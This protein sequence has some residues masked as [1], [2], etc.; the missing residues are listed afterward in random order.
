MAQFLPD[1]LKDQND[2]PEAI[3]AS[4]A[5]LN[6]GNTRD[7]QTHL[8][9]AVTL[10]GTCQHMCPDEE[11][12]RRQRESDIQLLERLMPDGTFHPKDWTL[13][14]T[15]VK[16]F[17]RSA[18]DYKLDVPEW[19][20]PADVLENVCGYLEEWVMDR[21]R[22][23]PDP[24][25]NNNATPNPLDVYQF[26]WDRT[27][28]I[29]KDFTL[30]NYVGTGGNCDARAVRCHERIARWH[31]MCEHQLSHIPDFVT[32]QSQQNIQELGQ[33]LI[34]LNQFYD[35]TQRRCLVEVASATDGSESRPDSSSFD[36]G[37]KSDHV[38]GAPPVDYD[39]KPLAN[40]GDPA[41]ASRL[42]GK[43]AVNSPHHGTAEPEMRGLY[44]L[45]TMNNDG[46]MEVRKYASQLSQ[47]RPEVFHTAPVQLAMSIFKVSRSP[48]LCGV[49][50]FGMEFQL[51]ASRP[52][53]TTT[54]H[55]SSRFFDRRQR[56]TCL[57][58]S[59]SNMW[60]TCGK[61]LSRLVHALMA[62]N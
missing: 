6:T 16:R 5:L 20:R 37:C 1:D 12:L 48:V 10:M 42:V 51:F 39:G 15:M 60:R 52:R 9:H 14:N 31:T 17:R 8:D 62:A 34:S 36:H 29:R 43:N 57:R 22:Q 27:R 19:V 58:V 21:D 23:G 50:F 45:Q 54:M 18:A 47:E 41:M 25:F 32:Q 4:N 7:D 55:D 26:I 24:R 35:D 38:N 56:P 49:S 33:A 61:K 53:K 59:C 28:M 13:R 2:N 11:I 40:E 46:G 30:Q 44:I 3:A